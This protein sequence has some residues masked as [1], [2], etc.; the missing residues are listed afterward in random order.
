MKN[1]GLG[2]I[3]AIVSAVL[4]GLMPLLTKTIYAS[5]SNSYT[6]AFLRMVLGTI[7]F[8]ILFKIT[9]KESL[10]ISKHELKQLVIC[11]LA[12]GIT[13]FLLY[14]SYNHLAS[15]LATTIHFVY[16]VFVVIGSV[17]FKIEKLTKRKLL[18]CALCMAGIL[19]FYTPGGNISIMGILIALLSGITYAYYTVYLAASDLLGMN[20]YKLSYWIHLISAVMLGILALILRKFI[21]PGT[22]NGWTF[23]LMLGLL[24]AT[25]SFLYQRAAKHAGAQNTAMLSTFEPLTSVIVG[26][27]V[28]SEAL[29]G[30]NILGI[31]FILLSVILLSTEGRKKS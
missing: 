21:W 11:A 6:V 14:T 4:Y 24:T 16:P 29:T 20:A 28:Y 18:C 31:V 3:L 7:T 8:L 15:G 2:F 22:F 13:P 12:Y 5:G 17:L 9:S 19:A 26:Y 27:F 10:G 1:K 30:R 25:A 23:M